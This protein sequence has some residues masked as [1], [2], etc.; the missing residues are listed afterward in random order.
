M[1]NALLSALVI[2]AAY[3][4]GTLQRPASADSDDQARIRDALRDIARAEQAQAEAMKDSLREI[5]RAEHA[6][7]DAL[8]SI[9]DSI[10]SVR[11]ALGRCSR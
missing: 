4:L 10:G 5:A 11:D 3:A 7:A 9:K 8:R 6:Q 2:L 1:R